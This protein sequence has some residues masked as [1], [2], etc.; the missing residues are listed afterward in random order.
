MNEKMAYWLTNNLYKI[1]LIL[2]VI[3][4]V[5]FLIHLTG[6]IE[7]KIILAFGLIGLAI[8]YFIIPVAK[9]KLE[10]AEGYQRFLYNLIYWGIAVQILCILGKVELFQKYTMFGTIGFTTLILTIAFS[11]FYYVSKNERVV[12]SRPLVLRLILIGIIM[13]IIRFASFSQINETFH[14]GMKTEYIQETQ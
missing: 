5:G 12:F 4:I 6:K 1:E 13:T 8:L 11:L 3:S 14:N 9:K 10:N 7:G 2:G